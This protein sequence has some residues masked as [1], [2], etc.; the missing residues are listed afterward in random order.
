MSRVCDITG[1]SK[2]F[3][4]RVSHSNRKTKRCYLVNLH[5]VALASD[6]LGRKFKMK[7]ASRT[8]RTIDFK[9]GLDVYLLGTS[10]RKLT[11]EAKKIKKKIRAA[12]AAGKS[13]QCS[14]L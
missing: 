12:V 1:L 4:N 6:V 7:V 2:S 13:L 5:S 11:D 9:G 8:L 3:G 14:V 10:S